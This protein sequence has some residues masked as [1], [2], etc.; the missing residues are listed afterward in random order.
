MPMKTFKP[1][2]QSRRFMTVEDFS[3][4]TKKAP[5]KSLLEPL[6]KT[7]GRNNTGS[8]TVRFRGGGHKRMYR[9]IDFKRDKVGVPA[10][11]AA[12]EYDPKPEFADCFVVL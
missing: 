1:Y 7:G 10:T 8:I 3:D 9:K 12:I 2:T 4:L 11:V 5:E 6:R